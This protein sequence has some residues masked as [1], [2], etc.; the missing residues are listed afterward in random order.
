[1]NLLI[2]G[3]S[4]KGLIFIGSLHYLF[5]TGKISRIDKF[6]GCSIGSVIGI[7]MILGVEPIQ[8][9]QYIMDINFSNYTNM[10]VNL[11]LNE[12]TLVGNTFFD[13]WEKIFKTYEDVEITIS[14]FNKKYECNI[15]I[16]STCID[17][18]QAVI[19]NEEDYPNVKVFDAI[20]ASS[21]I[22][23]VFPPRKINDSY[24]IDGECKCYYNSFN[25][26][27]D[28]ETIVLKLPD[29]KFSKDSMQNFTGYIKEVLCTL[30][31]DIPIKN[32]HLTLIVKVPERFL[33][34][35]DF[36]DITNKDKTELFLS[37]IKQAEEFYAG[38]LC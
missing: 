38:K 32:N 31:Q 36:G 27:I 26:H 33:D 14:E 8:L 6:Y 24:Y 20:V 11:L 21:S 35:F 15:N 37:G 19:F 1:M 22:P 12:F 4:Y 18:R 9:Y 25:D 16:S 28:D 30:T 29:I 10:D 13:Y 23:F 5:K 34:K 7:F 2:G 17:T 3:G